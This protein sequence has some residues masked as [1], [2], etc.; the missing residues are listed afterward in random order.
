MGQAATIPVQQLPQLDDPASGMSFADLCPLSE[1]DEVVSVISLPPGN[2]VGFLTLASHE[3]Q[4]KRIRLE[5][6]PGMTAKCIHCDECW[7]G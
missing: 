5:D 2:V 3:G 6:L 4:V 7:Q 1:K